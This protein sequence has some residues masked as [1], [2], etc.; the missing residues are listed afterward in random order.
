M[1]PVLECGAACVGDRVE[2]A[3]AA[4]FFALFVEEAELGEPGRLGVEGGVGEGPHVADRAGDLLFELV[5][6]G[7]AAGDQA[8]DEVGDGG[9]FVV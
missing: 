9:E 4:G 5:G 7:G 2:A 1:Q 8:E 6:G 3:A